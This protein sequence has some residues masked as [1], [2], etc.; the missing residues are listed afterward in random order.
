MLICVFYS[1]RMW[2]VISENFF[3]VR[4]KDRALAR[5]PVINL[6]PFL[7]NYVHSKAA[8]NV[9]QNKREIFFTNVNS[10]YVLVTNHPH[11]VLVIVNFNHPR[12]HYLSSW[13]NR[14]VRSTRQRLLQ[15]LHSWESRQVTTVILINNVRQFSQTIKDNRPRDVFQISTVNSGCRLVYGCRD[16]KK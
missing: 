15:R 13:I 11:L 10:G 6:S 5:L 12:S 3:F 16:C 2:C 9:T 7:E 8:K 1:S 14:R 4:I